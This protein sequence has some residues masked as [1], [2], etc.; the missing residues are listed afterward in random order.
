MR[1]LVLL[2][3]SSVL[4][5]NPF[6]A[7]DASP[8]TAVAARYA[9]AIADLSNQLRWHDAAGEKRYH[10]N[11]VKATQELLRNVDG[12]V[13]VAIPASATAE[14]AKAALDSLLGRK[15]GDVMQDVAFS[16]DLPVG[17]FLIVGAE[18]LRGGPAITED[19]MSFRAYRRA[20][21]LSFV[22]QIDDL[23]SGTGDPSLAYLHAL[24]LPNSP[25]AGE[26]WFLAWAAVPPRSPYTIALRLFAFDGHAFRTVWS[27][28]DFIARPLFGDAVGEAVTLAP[29]GGFV[30]HTV[31][32]FDAPRA[33]NEQYVLLPGGPRKVAQFETNIE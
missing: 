27:S 8:R 15:E 17:S 10:E 25:V 23:R 26:F 19:A 29:D 22:G 6:F 31:P 12:F 13:S 33:L 21:K 30:L 9:E 5:S 28:P 20:E 32:V 7:Q 11:S 18:L 3:M 24:A 2:G 14:Q 4:L 1:S 16:V